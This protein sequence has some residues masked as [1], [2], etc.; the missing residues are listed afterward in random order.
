M[1]VH[2]E[3]L[4]FCEI[5]VLQY[6]CQSHLEPGVEEKGK[7]QRKTLFMFG[8]FF[9]KKMFIFIDEFGLYLHRCWH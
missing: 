9:L 7:V 3:M 6:C 2:T 1:S 8:L 5:R 4:K